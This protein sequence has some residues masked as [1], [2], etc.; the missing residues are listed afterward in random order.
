VTDATGVASAAITAFDSSKADANVNN[1]FF[2]KISPICFKLYSAQPSKLV[3]P[4]IA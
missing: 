1:A 2:I 3:A 4:I